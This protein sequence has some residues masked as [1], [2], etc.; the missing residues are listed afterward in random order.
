MVALLGQTD[1][2]VAQEPPLGLFALAA[3]ISLLL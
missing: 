3:G 1:L 2:L